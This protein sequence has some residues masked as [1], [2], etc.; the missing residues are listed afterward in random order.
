MISSLVLALVI[1]Q[2][3]PPPQQLR[4]DPRIDIPVTGALVAGWI[5]S[6]AF[7]KDLA[8][9]ECR[10]CGTNGFDNSIRLLFNPTLSQSADGFHGWDTA[11]T[12]VG[13]IAVPVA[14]IGIDAI[15]AAREGVFMKAFWT[16]VVLML[17][18][19]FS[20]LAV[21]QTVKFLA[22]RARPY[23]IG[24]PPELLESGRDPPD[25]NLS[26][27]SG[28]TTLAFA[29]TT[30]AATIASLRGYRNAWVM[31]VVG[32]PLAITTG[33]LRMAADKHWASDVLVGA[34]VG[35]AFGVLMP[36]LLHG[37]VGP[38]EA[39]VVPAPNGIA[40]TGRF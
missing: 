12:V 8:P 14:M 19:T 1:S 35:T 10:L 26:F 28:H 30:S 34:A 32:I 3:A 15:F 27:F 36:T 33:I 21:N 38:L 6:D 24:A 39:R 13:F 29:L 40:L 2:T 25:N 17:E 20:A 23:T 37:R 11:S 9:A 4:W 5:I 7:K 31:W 18:A 22:G 16:D